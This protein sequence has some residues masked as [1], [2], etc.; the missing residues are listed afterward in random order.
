M[1]QKNKNQLLSFVC[2]REK[3]I[4]LTHLKLLV[5]KSFSKRA[6]VYYYDS[7][8][9]MERCNHPNVLQLLEG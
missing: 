5:V 6:Q 7:N 3:A 9:Q 4:T 1:K 8:L 2:Q